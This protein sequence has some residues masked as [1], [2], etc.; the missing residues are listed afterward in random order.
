MNMFLETAPV[1]DRRQ[2]QLQLMPMIETRSTIIGLVLIFIVGVVLRVW[3]ISYMPVLLTNDSPDYLASMIAIAKNLDFSRLGDWRMPGYPLFLAALSYVAGYMSDN[4]LAAQVLVDLLCIPLAYLLGREFRSRAV[5]LGLAG[6]IAVNPVYILNAHAIMTEG[7][8]LFLLLLATLISIKV[9]RG[10]RKLPTAILFGI[11]TGLGILTRANGIAYFLVLTL[12][13]Y[14]GL[15]RRE[16]KLA[17]QTIHAAL[18]CLVVTIMLIGIWV[19]R[20]ALQCGIVSITCNNNR[21]F[22]VFL[23]QNDVFDALLPV[24]KSINKVYD[25]SHPETIWNFIWQLRQQQPYQDEGLAW[26]IVR[27][28]ITA[29]PLSYI[30][31]VVTS[32]FRFGGVWPSWSDDSR[33]HDASSWFMIMNDSQMLQTQNKSMAAIPDLKPF[34]LQRDTVQPTAMSLLFSRIGL[35]YLQIF[36]GGIFLIVI[37][38]LSYWGLL[39]IRFGRGHLPDQYRAVWPILI[40]CICIAGLHAVSVSPFERATT[41]FDWII[42]LSLLIFASAIKRETKQGT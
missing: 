3:L 7:L 10:D 36:R 24:T 31:A 1:D 25:P 33:L 4:I 18:V 16:F 23:W 41:P 30:S 8:F 34:T 21:N 2:H 38:M 32:L 12:L 39:R 28:Q 37:V 6:F 15:L 26:Q 19:N 35:I 9:Y 42:F 40:A 11:L 5:A 14:T 20:N 29:H 13:A 22:I 27:E 17:K